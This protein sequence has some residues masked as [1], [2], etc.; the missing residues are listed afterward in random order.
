M[1][2]YRRRFPARVPFAEL[3]RAKDRKLLQLAAAGCPA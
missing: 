3:A 2:T 1:W